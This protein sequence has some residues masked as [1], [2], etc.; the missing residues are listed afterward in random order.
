M[1]HVLWPQAGA[2]A[3]QHL[4]Q[5]VSGALLIGQQTVAGAPQLAGFQRAQV[6]VQHGRRQRDARQVFRQQALQVG[7]VQRGLCRA[8]HQLTGGGGVAPRVHGPAQLKGQHSALAHLQP[9]LQLAQQAARPKHQGGGSFDLGE[10]LQLG[11]KHLGQGQPGVQLRLEAIGAVQRIQQVGPKAPH[12]T[13]TRQGAYMAPVGAT[14]AFQG[15]QVR[16]G[17]C[18]SSQWQVIGL[19]RWRARG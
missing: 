3:L 18:Q 2:Q 19:N 4:V 16:M 14:N 5:A 13:A 15:G 1:Q 6:Q 7:H 12:H 10:Q 9:H 11:L 17:G 8:H